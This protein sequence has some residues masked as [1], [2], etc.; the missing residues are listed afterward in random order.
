[1]EQ[2]GFGY[3]SKITGFEKHTGLDHSHR[4]PTRRAETEVKKEILWPQPRTSAKSKWYRRCKELRSMAGWLENRKSHNVFVMRLDWKWD[5]GWHK[6]LFCVPFHLKACCRWTNDEGKKW[7]KW[8]FQICSGN[9]Y[10]IHNLNQ[11]LW[12]WPMK[13]VKWCPFWAA[14]AQ[15]LLWH[16]GP[17]HV[18]ENDWPR[19][20][21]AQE[22]CLFFSLVDAI[23]QSVTERNSF[24]NGVII[25]T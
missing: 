15:A 12:L 10:T 5:P 23:W 25:I 7:T 16:L 3:S 21:Q 14:A 13:W 6:L 22:G 18:D 4:L 17:S 2:N 11:S 8:V 9:N 19:D 24:T 1:M 20:N